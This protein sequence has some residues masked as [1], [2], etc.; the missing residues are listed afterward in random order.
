[1]PWARC[2]CER[3]RQPQCPLC[4]HTDLIAGIPAPRAHLAVFAP[5][6][7]A[8]GTPGPGGRPAGGRNSA[9]LLGPDTRGARCVR[10]GAA[11]V[12]LPRTALRRPRTA[13]EAGP[14][15][16]RAAVRDRRLPPLFPASSSRRPPHGRGSRRRHGPGLRHGR[17]PEPAAVVQAAVRGLPR[18]QHHQHDHLVPRRAGLLRHPAP[19][20]PRPHVSTGTARRSQRQP[21]PSPQQPLS[22][23]DPRARRSACTDAESP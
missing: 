8:V 17:H 5:H 16:R 18:C 23:A 14:A 13:A 11:R 3:Q 21:V 22:S 4:P 7:A 2:S 20:P 15:L 12:R 19:P 10:D 6:S 9:R 1:M